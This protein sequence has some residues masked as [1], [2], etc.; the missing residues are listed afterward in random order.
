MKK[1]MYFF[2]IVVFI[3]IIISIKYF[4]YRTN[5]NSSLKENLEYE[6]YKDDEIYGSKLATLI[7]RAIDSNER[8]SVAKDSNKFFINNDSS[9]I[10]IEIDI[11]DTETRYKMETIY[12]GGI[13]NFIIYYGSIKFKCS[14]IEYHKSTNKIKYI[15][16]EQT[17]Q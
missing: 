14:K 15:L 11:L 12:N 10:S 7:N 13:E 17:T 3:V 9:S 2:V 4:N 1:I 16:F 8:N 5:Y 6:I